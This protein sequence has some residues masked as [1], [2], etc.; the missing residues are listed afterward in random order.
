MHQFVCQSP[1]HDSQHAVTIL[2]QSHRARKAQCYGMD[3]GYDAESIYRQIRE[4]LESR[5]MIPVRERKRKRISERYRRQNLAE[6]DEAIYHQRN[7]VE[8]VF[9][10]LKRRFGENL[11]ARKYWYQVKEIKIKIVLYNLRMVMKN[12]SLLFL[13][14]NSTEP[15]NLK[16]KWY[17]CRIPPVQT[18]AG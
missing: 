17:H 3:K 14:R 2:R 18:N 12:Y 5:S 9:S 4:E 7:L 1:I 6:F 15:K 10:V 16:F 13:L 8:T 11:K